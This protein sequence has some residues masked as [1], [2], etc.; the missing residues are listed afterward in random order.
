MADSGARDLDKLRQEEEHVALQE[1]IRQEEEQ[2]ARF[3][4]QN[5]FPSYETILSSLPIELSAEYGE[6]NHFYMKLAY[7]N[8][9]DGKIL[10]QCGRS[11]YRRGGERAMHANFE[12]LKYYS[13]LAHHPIT[14]AACGDVDM[15]WHGIGEWKF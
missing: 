15:A 7:E 3:V 10:K 2:V 5:P 8:L 13:P 1:Q 11:I 6:C 12:V 4:E 14:Q 9:Q